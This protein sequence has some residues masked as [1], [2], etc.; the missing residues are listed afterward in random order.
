MHARPTSFPLAVSLG[1]HRLFL[2][3]L[4]F[5]FALAMG[6]VAI[7]GPG[8]RTVQFNFPDTSTVRTGPTST[9]VPSTH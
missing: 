5:L 1:L 8:P 2:L 3:V 6:A 7:Q 9:V 4:V